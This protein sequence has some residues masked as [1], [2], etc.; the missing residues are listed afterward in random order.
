MLEEK[1]DNLQEAD[2]TNFKNEENEVVDQINNENAE[3]SE[4]TS[5][6]ELRELPSITYDDLSFE[7]LVAHLKTLLNNNKLMAIQENLE[8]IKKALFFQLINL[9]KKKKSWF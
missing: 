5:I 3:D 7:N 6:E 1:N 4:D 9:L 2:G 8:S